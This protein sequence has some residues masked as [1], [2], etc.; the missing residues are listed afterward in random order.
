M[1]RRTAASGIEVEVVA[2][3][4]DLYFQGRLATDDNFEPAV[5]VARLTMPTDG[6]AIDL[7]ACLGIVSVAIGH[8]APDGI[9]LA[10]E[11][12]PALQPGLVQTCAAAPAGNVRIVAAAVGADIGTANYHA[13]P[14]GGA[15]GYVA[16]DGGLPVEQ[17]TVDRLV[18][19]Q[20]LERVDFIKLDIEG[21]ELAAL[22]GATETIRAHH[23]V[24]VA[25]LNPFCLWRY[26]RTLPQDLVQWIRAEY[27]H[28][29]SIDEHGNVV[30]LVSDAD[31]DQ[32]LASVGTAG[33]LVD[34]VASVRPIT[35]P[36][37]LWVG[38]V[39]V[40][41]GDNVAPSAPEAPPSTWQRVAAR[42]RR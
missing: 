35:F 12:S 29:W 23:P 17:I 8:V 26:G 15:W 33:G 42:L 4:D 20:G 41:D 11:A 28:T 25:E 40:A 14:N 18:S 7:G 37:P 32:M 30:E 24:L 10:V 6:V 19:D 27:P 22:Q 38:P 36:E 5:S 39:A 21:H 34:L 3:A 31:V 9:V 2:R 13:D 1:R 16:D